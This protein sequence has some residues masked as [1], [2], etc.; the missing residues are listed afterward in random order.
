MRFLIINGP[1]L[2]MLG[3][4]QPEIYGT[5]TY[6]DL[7]QLVTET[8]KQENIDVD[9]FQ[10]NHEGAIVD[11][12]QMAYGKYDGFIINPGAY[13]H[14]SIAILDALNTVCIPAAEVHISNIMERD[15]FRRISYAG[16]A[17]QLHYIGLGL[18]GYADAVIGLKEMINQL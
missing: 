14:T 15:E 18:Q 11:E 3:L 12:I 1:N 2:N 8:C 10:S 7:V 17:C 6:Q 13:T 4:R 16:M 5:E 9:F